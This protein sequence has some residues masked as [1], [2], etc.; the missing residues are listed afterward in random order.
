M[1]K[2]TNMKVSR[3]TVATGVAWTVPAVAVASTVPAFAA[4]PCVAAAPGNVCKYPGNKYG[5]KHAYMVSL[6]LTNT[7]S[8][9]ATVTQSEAYVM[10]SDGK[11]GTGG[12]FYDKRPDQGG[13]STTSV[14]LQPGE[15]RTVYLVVDQTGNSKN[16]AGSY[17]SKLLVNGNPAS[18]ECDPVIISTTFS[19]TAPECTTL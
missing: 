12:G 4:S 7:T 15:T 10:F 9:P 17:Y 3:R 16:E 1:E 2:M 11:H 13:T 14:T 18:G 5:L 19:A 8:E 6:T